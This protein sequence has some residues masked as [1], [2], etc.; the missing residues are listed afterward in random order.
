VLFTILRKSGLAADASIA[1]IDLTTRQ[2]K[3]ILRGGHAPRYLPTGHLLYASRGQLHA[4]GF[5]AKRL[6]PRPPSTPVE[7]VQLA[8]TGGFN[9]DF[10]VSAT[11]TLAYVPPTA[12]RLLTL[13]WVDP[14][15]GR[16]EPILAEPRQ[17]NSPIISPNGMRVALDIRGENRDIW[18]L[19]FGRPVLTKITSGP[20]EDNMPAWSP[21]STRVFFGSDGGGG[22]FQIFSIAADGAGSARKE[23]AGRA[24]YMPLHMPVAG[25]LLAFASGAG[26]PGGD[27]AVVTLGRDGQDA[28]EQTLLG[29]AGLEGTASVSPDGRWVAYQSSEPEGEPEVYVRSYPDV[30]LRLEKISSG[31]GMQALWGPRGSNELFYWTLKGA[32]NVVSVTSTPDLRIGPPRKV[33]LGSGYRVPVPFAPWVYAVSPKDGRLLLLKPEP[34]TEGLAPIKVKFDWSE[35]LTRL[36]PINQA[37]TSR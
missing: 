1:V 12:P 14:R 13:V 21:D 34:Q 33:P 22:V 24:S 18:M 29:G 20:T 35:E 9:A 11:G 10:D 16:E 3:T 19:E 5:D 30:K 28:E 7:G 2:Q 6:E 17:Y 31:G 32:L 27:V 15:N 25:T 36:V 4:M 23:F 8:A 26:Y 37:S